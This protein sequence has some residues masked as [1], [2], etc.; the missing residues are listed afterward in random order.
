MK[1]K[2]VQDIQD[3]FDKKVPY[4][5]SQLKKPQDNWITI[6]SDGCDSQTKERGV[7]LAELFEFRVFA[8]PPRLSCR[9]R[10]SLDSLYGTY[11]GFGLASASMQRDRLE[12]GFCAV[13]ALRSPGT[14]MHS[15]GSIN[16]PPL[17]RLRRRCGS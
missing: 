1:E 13:E 2:G 11:A 12:L 9:S 10:V 7:A 4:L 16:R 17:P 8:L 14:S 3:F 6:V 15:S 5:P